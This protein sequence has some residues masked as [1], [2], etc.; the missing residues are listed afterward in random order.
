MRK[1]AVVAAGGTGGH[2]FPAQALSEALIARGWRIVLASDE[3][4]AAFAESFPAEE[5]IGLSA[6]TYKPRDPVGMALAGLSIL[7]GVMQARTAFRR[8]KPDVVVGFG[9]YPSVPGLLA[10]ITLNLPTVMHEQNS[11][12]G[13]ANRRLVSHVKAVAC[14]FPMLQ[15][16]PPKVAQSAVVVG[17][18]VRP[19]IRALYELAYTPPT[20]D[21]RIHLL[22]TG[23]SQGARLL[24]ELMPE[25]IRKLPEALRV[26]LKVQQQTRAENMEQARKVYADAMV[27]AEIAPFFRDMAGRLKD[28]HLVV[29][30]AGAGTVC[31]FAIAGK[32][33]ILVPLAIALDDDQGQNA[34]VMVDAHGAQMA[35]EHQ[36]TVDSM[37]NALEKLL[38]NPDRLARMAAGARSIAKPDAAERLAD[39]VEKTAAGK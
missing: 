32:P 39:L 25:A 19:E 35:R 17:N 5:R 37:A 24:S 31:E 3:R 34:Q 36:L 11:V 9:G 20:Q 30:R 16:A 10:G 26:R 4:A 27:D 22:I 33:A 13:R 29:G 23:G 1:I 12:M 18:P 21:G 6:R 15:K 38:T 2:L 28:A 14:A 7:R 8:I